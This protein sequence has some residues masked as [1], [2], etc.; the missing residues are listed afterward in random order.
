MSRAPDAAVRNHDHDQRHDRHD[1]GHDVLAGVLA[2][3]AAR[4]AA[5]VPAQDQ[6]QAPEGAR[7]WRK[8]ASTSMYDAWLVAWAPGAGIPDHHHGG[9]TAAFHV[10]RGTLVE[11]T[12]ARAR[13]VHSGGAASVPPWE[14][15][16]VRN[17][18]AVPALSLHVYSPPLGDSWKAD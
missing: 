4:L 7:S 5:V 11:R 9:A 6:L 2:V 3:I 17:L 18:G 12:E 1:Q 8:V 16:A 10:V 14:R 13:V 15:H